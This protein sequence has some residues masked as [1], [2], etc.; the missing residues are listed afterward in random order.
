MLSEGSINSGIPAAQAYTKSVNHKNWVMPFDPL[1]PK[2]LDEAKNAIKIHV[3]EKMDLRKEN[4][5]LKAEIEQAKTIANR[6]LN[7]IKTSKK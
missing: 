4:D 2:T 6:L 5:N 3:K 1:N 7:K